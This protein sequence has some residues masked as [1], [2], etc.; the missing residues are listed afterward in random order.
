MPEAYPSFKDF[1]QLCREQE[2]SVH[3]D[4]IKAGTLGFVKET[5]TFNPNPFYAAIAACAEVH[6]DTATRQLTDK[7][8]QLEHGGQ[9]DL[10]AFLAP[11]TLTSILNNSLEPTGGLPWDQTFTCDKGTAIEACEYAEGSF[12]TVFAQMEAPKKKLTGE[13]GIAGYQIITGENNRPIAVRKGK[14]VPST[15]SLVDVCVNGIAYPAGSLFRM[16]L[17][18]DWDGHTYYTHVREGRQQRIGAERVT[19]MTFR[20]LTALAEEPAVRQHVNPVD[21]S[22]KPERSKV[23][24]T[25]TLEKMQK[26]AKKALKHTL[27]LA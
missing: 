15:L 3:P 17:R 18:E 13:P 24:A 21:F 16:Q 22:T 9:S 20:R 19:H 11:R 25:Y 14:G 2:V 27:P 7:P 8:I 6:L 10:G 4:V 12:A 23:Y 5:H 26:L 1:Q